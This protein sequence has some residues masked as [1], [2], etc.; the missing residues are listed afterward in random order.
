[1]KQVRA[2]KEGKGRKGEEEEEEI[3]NPA[4]AAK[5]SSCLCM[6]PR[7]AIP[8][9]SLLHPMPPAA[10]R[11][12]L[13]HNGGGERGATARCLLDATPVEEGLRE[14]VRAGPAARALWPFFVVRH[15]PLSREQWAQLP[16]PCPGLGRAL[17]RMFGHSAE[18]ARLLVQHL[19]PSD[20]EQL[21]CAALCLARL[22]RV[23]DQPLPGP[24]V[25]RIV[26]LALALA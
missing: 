1:M 24:I 3:G 7:N 13:L 16:T 2:R 17:P 14:M 12:A 21:R 23:L 25:G 18:Q 15:C 6:W 10:L 4:K 22:Q 11:L 19:P 8:R 9:H 26:S 5:G 20:A